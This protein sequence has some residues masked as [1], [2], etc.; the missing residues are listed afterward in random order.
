MLDWCHW[1]FLGIIVVNELL[2]YKHSDSILTVQLLL[3]GYRLIIVIRSLIGP[4]VATPLIVDYPLCSYT[5][6][7]GNALAVVSTYYLVI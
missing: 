1:Y 5:T 6:D 3:P 4:S 7:R 2:Q